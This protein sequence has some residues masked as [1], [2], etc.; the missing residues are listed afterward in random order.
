M[1]K[2]LFFLMLCI[3]LLL[4]GCQKTPEAP[5]AVQAEEDGAD[6]W[7]TAEAHTER[8][9]FTGANIGQSGLTAETWILCDGGSG[10]LWEEG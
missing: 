8:L 10:T 6:W 2:R 9:G 5:P 1:K 7:K 3:S 4:S